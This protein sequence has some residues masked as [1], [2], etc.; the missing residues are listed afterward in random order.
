M[1]VDADDNA[2]MAVASETR[3]RSAAR[4]S[5]SQ[6][7]SAIGAR[8][9]RALE[10]GDTISVSEALINKPGEY[11]LSIQVCGEGR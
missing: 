6:Q 9:T 11:P 5:F 7:M 2:V 10:G 3:S 8:L 1:P 4:R